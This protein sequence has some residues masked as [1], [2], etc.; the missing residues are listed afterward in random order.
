M[1]P[2]FSHSLPP[3]NQSS[4]TTLPLSLVNVAF[5]FV[6]LLVLSNTEL[7]VSA[8][9]IPSA[10]ESPAF[11]WYS[12]TALRVALSYTPLRSRFDI[13]P[14]SYSFFCSRSTSSPSMPV[15]SMLPDAVLEPVSVRWVR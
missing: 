15:R 14:R 8:P 2:L 7:S 9:A 11:F 5:S 4:S 10:E 6:S 12:S 13:K 3:L 1:A